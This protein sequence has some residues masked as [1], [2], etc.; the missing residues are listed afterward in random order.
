M[1]GPSIEKL[2]LQPL[3]GLLAEDG[4]KPWQLFSMPEVQA[5]SSRDI[6]SFKPTEMLSVLQA[7]VALSNDPMLMLRLGRK[8]EIT[9]LGTFGFGLM[10]SANLEEALKLYL[11]YA[12]LVGPGPSFKVQ[13]L[14][15]GIA[16]RIQLDV[17]NPDQKQLITEF[18][19]SQIIAIAET[20]VNTEIETGE[21]HLNYPPPADQRSYQ[22]LFSMPVKFNQNYSQL[23]IPDSIIKSKVTTANAAGHVIFQQQCEELLRELNG[24][25]NFSAAIRRLLIHSGGELPDINQVA[26]RLYVSESTL[27]RRLRNESTNF[28]AICDEVRNVLACEYLTTTPLTLAEIA[29]LLDYAEAASFRR[30]FIRWN[31]TT[32]SQYRVQSLSKSQR[33][34]G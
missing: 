23:L 18:S 8:V 15:N 6:K 19:F 29:S 13:K 2:F 4:I 9:S 31:Q 17:G 7:A 12:A 24:V 22:A 25:E 16:L 5:L 10:S 28:R 20:L 27:R 21:V 34:Y 32:P 26:E 33:V 11:R 14:N 3:L 30:A 1:A